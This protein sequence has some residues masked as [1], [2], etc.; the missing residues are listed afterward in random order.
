LP[1]FRQKDDWELAETAAK[2]VAR[3]AIRLKYSIEAETE[4]N[5]RLP[6]VEAAV[7]RA[8]AEGRGWI[9]DVQALF[10]GEGDPVIDVE[11]TNGSL[12]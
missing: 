5:E 7:R 6:E 11:G 9:L 12:A 3:A 8:L 4:I 1:D 2:K 10:L